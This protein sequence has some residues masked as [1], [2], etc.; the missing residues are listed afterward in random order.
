MV[1]RLAHTCSARSLVGALLACAFAPLT[2][3]RLRPVSG[4]AHV[5]VAGRDPARRRAQ[6]G[7]WFNAGTF[8]AGTYWLYTSIHIFGQAPSGWPSR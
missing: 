5:A 3:G 4:G 6:L 8:A 2:G 1:A 7:F